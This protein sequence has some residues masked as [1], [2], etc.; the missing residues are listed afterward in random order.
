MN[1]YTALG[2]RS[3]H[4]ATYCELDSAADGDD[5]FRNEFNTH[6][7]LP[8]AAVAFDTSVLINVYKHVV[9]ESEHNQLD[10]VTKV[11]GD[12]AVK[13][14][15]GATD[16]VVDNICGT[17][18]CVGGWGVQV[19]PLYKLR[20]SDDDG[21]ESVSFAPVTVD[22]KEVDWL[23]ASAGALT[24]KRYINMDPMPDNDEFYAL[25]WLFS[26][27]RNR[28]ELLTYLAWEISIRVGA[29]VFLA[30]RADALQPNPVS[31]GTNQITPVDM[32]KYISRE[33]A[34][35]DKTQALELQAQEVCEVARSYA[36]EHG[37]CDTAESA[38]RDA[39]VWRANASL[40]QTPH[41]VSFN[42]SVKGV[43]DLSPRQIEE[44]IEIHSVSIEENVVRLDL[45]YNNQSDER[46]YYQMD[47]VSC[48]DITDLVIKRV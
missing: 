21:Y 1:N 31:V 28:W 32:S 5:L 4:Y 47:Q 41:E 27:A 14:R 11:T 29:E 30:I 48:L 8:D 15:Q 46:G 12:V 44:G 38:L 40:V 25:C 2:T 24:G 18:C 34:E 20:L 22:G 35:K 10:Y 37:W 17:R 23:I 26:G 19:S 43:I 6:L 42:I 16:G 9:N 45:N 3:D 33:E 13:V 7:L 36:A 39:H